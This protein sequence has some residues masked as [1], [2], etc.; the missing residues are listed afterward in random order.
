MVKN[1]NNKK[2]TVPSHCSQISCKCSLHFIFGKIKQI[3]PL[4]VLAS[5]ALDVAVIWILPDKHTSQIQKLAP[6]E[7]SLGLRNPL[8][9]VLLLEVEEALFWNRS[10]SGSF[11]ISF[12]AEAPLPGPFC[13]VDRIFLKVPSRA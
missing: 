6:L 9:L 8:W 10:E 2:K 13:S 12:V 11:F 1:N 7:H 3:K 5:L 4:H